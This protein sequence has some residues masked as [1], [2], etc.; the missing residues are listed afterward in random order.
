LLIISQL[1]EAIHITTLFNFS[2]TKI[3]FSFV[4]KIDMFSG[5]NRINNRSIIKY[6][7]I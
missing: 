3:I 4:Q 1:F 2:L 6:K 5:L 7:K